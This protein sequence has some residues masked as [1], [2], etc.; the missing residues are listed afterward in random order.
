MYKFP[1]LQPAF[2][3]TK[4]HWVMFA[5]SSFHKIMKAVKLGED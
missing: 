3:D 5:H 1:S 4:N 2:I